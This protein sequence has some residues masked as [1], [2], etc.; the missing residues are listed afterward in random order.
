MI[1][2]RRHK[3]N[4]RGVS[5]IAILLVIATMGLL[6][7]SIT[8][9][10]STGQVSR[11]ND[12]VREQAFYINMG[13]IEY[14]L[15]QIDDG[16]D[17]NGDQRYL[18]NGQFTVTYDS[19]TG[20]ISVSS[21]VS[22]MYGTSNP[23][24]SIQG[25]TSGNMADCLEIHTNS[26]VF[27]SGE[28]NGLSYQNTCDSAIVIASMTVS[29]TQDD[30]EKL[31]DIF[32]GNTEVYSSAGV[33]SGVSVDVVD[34]TIPALSTI[35]SQNYFQFDDSGMD[36]KN[37]T[38]DY[39]MSDGTQKQAFVQFIA[40]DESACTN[41]DLTAS[42]GGV[43]NRD[44]LGGTLTNVC[45]PPTVVTIDSITVSWT[46]GSM[47]SRQLVKTV[48]TDSGGGGDWD[49]S[50]SSG[51]TVTFPTPIEMDSGEVVEQTRLRFDVGQDMRGFNFVI[52]YNFSDGTS[53]TKYANLYE[54]DMAACLQVGTAGMSTKKKT[55]KDQTWTNNCSLPILVD[56]VAT[57]W[58]S[59]SGS[60]EV[61]AINISGSDNWSG[62]AGE[63]VYADIPNAQIAGGQTM[64]VTKYTF[65]DNIDGSACFTHVIEMFDINA[66]T[67]SVPSY[68]P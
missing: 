25:P 18:G 31:T 11:T 46:Q 52:V 2:L 10:V 68:C 57:S 50:I 43:A 65:D 13:G 54:V 16:E 29:W 44:L 56:Q 42:V 35:S 3:L 14:A 5:V 38:I 27:A 51:G 45:D 1:R 59:W 66:G 32:I 39:V 60:H 47:P 15:K 62:G 7:G 67:V 19:Q 4:S 40:D 17:P 36:Y 24:F 30:G 49:G 12:L 26:A 64:D 63:G 41:I 61:T 21:D 48:Y 6:G 22:A 53:L 37:F 55:L 33:A 23:T 20:S 8:V 28:L 34:S 9:L 58:S